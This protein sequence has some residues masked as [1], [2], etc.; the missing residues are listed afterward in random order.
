MNLEY[1]VACPMVWAAHEQVHPD[2]G[3]TQDT[4]SSG[5]DRNAKSSAR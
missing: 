5:L 2:V 3:K 1:S 4:K